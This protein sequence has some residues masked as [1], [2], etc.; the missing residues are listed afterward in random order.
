M[1]SMQVATD[2]THIGGTARKTSRRCHR[3]QRSLVINCKGLRRIQEDCA[4]N[5][6]L[7]SA[8]NAHDEKHREWGLTDLAAFAVRPV[9]SSPHQL[10]VMIFLH[11]SIAISYC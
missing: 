9:Q 3:R 8:S 1:E 2:G 7:M 4:N 6:T 10:L 11:I 5:F